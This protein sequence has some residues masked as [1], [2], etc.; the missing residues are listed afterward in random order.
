MVTSTSSEHADPFK[1]WK[2]A[3]A[4]A[5]KNATISLKVQ[6]FSPRGKAEETTALIVRPPSSTSLSAKLHDKIVGPPFVYTHFRWL[7][8]GRWKAINR[9][10][11]CTAYFRLCNDYDG[12]WRALQGL[13]RLATD[14][15]AVSVGRELEGRSRFKSEFHVIRE[16]GERLLPR[17]KWA[18][19]HMAEYLEILDRCE[20]HNVHPPRKGAWAVYPDPVTAETVRLPEKETHMRLFRNGNLDDYA[21]RAAKVINKTDTPEVVRVLREEIERVARDMLEFK[22]CKDRETVW[23][24]LPMEGGL[25]PPSLVVSTEPIADIK[26]VIEKLEAIPEAEGESSAPPA[27]TP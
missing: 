3:S 18:V 2:G 22:G 19:G 8:D 27:Y 15:D 10:D 6:R 25:P 24:Y 12:L 9:V 23:E 7:E 14:N 13:E 5:H 11:L 20:A 21:F 26:G 1:Q 4:F 17:L 16:R